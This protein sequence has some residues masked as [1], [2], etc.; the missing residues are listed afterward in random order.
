MWLHEEPDCN[1]ILI[2][3]LC[4][5]MCGGRLSPEMEYILRSHLDECP[6][7]LKKVLNFKETLTEQE[8]YH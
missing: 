6:S 2:D 3:L 7:C 8:T 5:E 1:Q 4:Y